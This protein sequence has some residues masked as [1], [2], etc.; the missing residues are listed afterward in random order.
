QF[1][2]AI[3][4]VGLLIIFAIVADARAKN[5]ALLERADRLGEMA[6]RLYATVEEL[7]A[8]NEELADARLRADFSSQAKSVFLSDLS[9]EIAAPII[10]I[11]GDALKL[12]GN[13]DLSEAQRHL[14]DNL[15]LNGENLTAII[16]DVVEIARMEAGGVKLAPVDFELGDFIGELRTDLQ[17]NASERG[18]GLDLDISARVHGKVNGDFHLLREV[19]EFVLTNAIDANE[20]GAVRFSVAR[21]DEDIY[22]FEVCD[23]GAVLSAEML[24]HI[25]ELFHKNE[26]ERI[27]GATGLGLAIAEKKAGY[28]VQYFENYVGGGRRLHLQLPSRAPRHHRRQRH[29]RR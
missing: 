25:F 17:R 4:A 20:S 29:R 24:A 26:G 15:A 5:R 13:Q 3:A 16:D 9:N 23:R 28:H 2:I 18:I 1:V 8:A 6:K 10:A 27:K 14:V 12:C 22:A 21:G 19:L 11:L 7:N